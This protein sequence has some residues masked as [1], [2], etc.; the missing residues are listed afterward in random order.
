MEPSAKVGVFG[1]GYTYSGHPVSC[2]VALKTIEIYERDGI[3][4][5]AAKTGE[6]LQSRLQQFANHP[7]VGE[8]R[9]VGMI[10]AL[11]LVANK[12]SKQAFEGGT[13]GAYTQQ[14]CQEN[15]LLLRA[16]AGNNLAFCPPLIIDTAQVDEIIDKV[17]KS[18]DETLDFV[19][20][21]KLLV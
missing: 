18:L 8:V 2:A 19:Q 17:G 9:G 10:A 4:E 15:G 6:Y 20:Q 13:V 7:L 21:Q 11:E 12:T 1:H 16:M 14:R 5:H 3:Y